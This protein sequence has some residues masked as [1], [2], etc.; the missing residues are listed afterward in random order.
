MKE[1][2]TERAPRHATCILKAGH[3]PGKLHSYN[4]HTHTNF[5]FKKQKAT[6]I[7]IIYIK[8][9]LHNIGKRGKLA[10]QIPL[11]LA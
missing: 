1:R 6:T 4:Q 7:F 3:H 8:K 9:N 11:S 5:F 2:M 10:K